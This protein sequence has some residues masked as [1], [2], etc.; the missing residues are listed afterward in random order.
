VA[1]DTPFALRPC[2]A[3]FCFH[4]QDGLDGKSDFIIDR[5]SI[6]KWQELRFGLVIGGVFYKK[7]GS[8][9]IVSKEEWPHASPWDWP[10]ANIPKD[11]FSTFYSKT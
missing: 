10:A 6:P 2:A 1:F 3:G 4:R 11:Q 9:V 8:S 5:A 7:L